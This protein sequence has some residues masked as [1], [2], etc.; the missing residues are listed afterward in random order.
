MYS[1]LVVSLAEHP[2]YFDDVMEWCYREFWEGPRTDNFELKEFLSE[3][4]RKNKIPCSLVALCDGRPV[5]S[6][7]LM[8]REHDIN[9]FFPC[10]SGLYVLPG[11]R[12]LG[13]GSMLIENAL[14]RARTNGFSNVYLAADESITYYVSRGW[15]V[16]APDEPSE[17][18]II[19]RPSRIPFFPANPNML[20]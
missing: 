6:V 15:T 14:E 16:I 7:H 17:L 8:G 13:F 18:Y 12:K 4:L 5:G 10:L 20:H 1:K 19:S 11:Y 9:P 3:H 2:Q